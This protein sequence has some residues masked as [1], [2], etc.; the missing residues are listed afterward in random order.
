MVELLAPVRDE[1]SFSA[2]LNAGAD[3]VYLGLGQLNMRASSRGIEPAALVG[4]VGRGHER[5]V[6]V[7]VTL[8]TIVFDG[9][10]TVV[11]ELLAVCR[12]AAV[13]G[14]I[15]WDPAVIERVRELGLRVHVSTQA[16]VANVAAAR[17]YEGL[18]ARR[19]VPARE[20]SIEQVRELKRGTSLEVEGFA[21]GAMC[22]S[23][24]GRCFM[25][26]YESGRSAN[27][28]DC[29]Q[30]C[31]RRY[32]VTDVETGE[33]LAIETGGQSGTGEGYVMSPN[34]LCTLPILD[35]LVEAGVDGL[36]IEGRSRSAEYV[37]VVVGAYRRGLDAVAAGE[38]DQGLVEELMA[39]VGRVYN[40]GFSTGFLLG[41]PGPQSWADRYGSHASHTKEHVGKV[42]HCYKQAGVVHVALVRP[43]GV[44]EMVQLHG[45]T[46]GVVDCEITELR[47]DEQGNV[48]S[49]DRGEVTFPCA[50]LVRRNDQVYRLFR[51][52]QGQ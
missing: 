20:L 29:L 21:H 52:E 9:E 30:P 12:Q 34:D 43:L 47:T 36:K 50:E 44:G 24:S 1:V 17:F 7:Y 6:K 32:R 19:V 35:Q 48:S 13:D 42:L 31:R 38:F 3:A 40:R 5:G 39:E 49:V 28:G 25:S 10:L 2:A 23:V 14:V 16:S 22:V 11:D 18:G 8:N 45:P 26:Q 4:I 41:R 37:K 27:R 15:C 51:K 33:E 46:T